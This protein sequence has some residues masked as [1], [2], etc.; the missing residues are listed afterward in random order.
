MSDGTP[1][2]YALLDVAGNGSYRLQYRVA[3]KPASEQIGL[4][5]P[6]VLRQGPTGVGRVRQ[7]VHGR[8]C[9][10]GRVPRRWWRLAADEAGQPARSAPDGGERGR[11][12]GR[13]P[14]RLRP[15]T[16]GHRIAAPLARCAADRPGG[17]QPQGW[18][19]PPSPMARCSPRPPATA[20]RPPS[21]DPAPPFQRKDP[22]GYPLHGRHHAGH[23]QPPLVHRRDAAAERH[24]ESG[25]SIRCIRAPTRSR[26]YSRGC[27]ISPATKC[28]S[29]A[30]GR[31]YSPASARNDCACW[32]TECRWPSRKACRPT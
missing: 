1:K 32:W 31:C 3:G 10:R 4:H 18:Y 5:A 30:P 15:L 8:R 19:A 16:G 28:W 27:D 13:H 21:P 2:G 20:C 24:R 25:C 6:K 17:G 26:W 7:R 29:S 9:Q 23:P 22:H 11:R 14:A 12:P